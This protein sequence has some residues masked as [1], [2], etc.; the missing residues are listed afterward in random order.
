MKSSQLS[1]LLLLLPLLPLARST[2]S[3]STANPHR[4]RR[5]AQSSQAPPRLGALLNARRAPLSAL[6]APRHHYFLEFP[7]PDDDSVAD[8]SANATTAGDPSVPRPRCED[9]SAHGFL[10]RRGTNAHLN[11]LLV[12]FGGASE[13][14]A[15]P[16][17]DW[18]ARWRAGD[19]YVAAGGGALEMP[20]LRS[21]KGFSP[22][23]VEAGADL[24]GLG[25]EDVPIFL[26]G[27]EDEGDDEDG[28]TERSDSNLEA[29][30]AWWE[31]LGGDGSDPRDWSYLFVPHCTPS[32]PSATD[33][34]VRAVSDWITS[35]FEDAGGLDALVAVSG[36][37]R[38]GGCPSNVSAESG[39][40]AALFAKNVASSL[41]F[42]ST[43]SKA[44][45]VV[46]GATLWNAVGGGLGLEEAM[47]EVLLPE[48]NIEVAWVASKKSESDDS[49]S[50]WVED[51]VLKGME[52]E[53]GNSF[54]VFRPPSPPVED[55][56]DQTDLLT[57]SLYAFPDESADDGFA[58]FLDGIVEDMPWGNMGADHKKAI[59]STE[60][61]N[62]RLSFLSIFLIL[63]GLY[64]SS[65]AVYMLV[66]RRREQR[67]ED[68][69]TRSPHDLWFLALTNY[70]VI[71]LLC[72]VALPVILSLVVYAREGSGIYSLNLDFDSYLDIDTKEERVMMQYKTLL[73]YQMD[74]L[75][76]EE[77]NC[78]LMY[79][80]DSEVL[81][82]KMRR[83]LWDEEDAYEQ[84]GHPWRDHQH[85]DPR[86]RK[87]QYG[88]P[89]GRTVITFFY[90][91]RRGGNVFT[92]ETIQSIRD[93]EEFLV[94]VPGFDDF[95]FRRGGKECYPIDSVVPYFYPGL[96]GKTGTTLVGDI[97]GVL[98]SLTGSKDIVAK[99]DKYYSKEVRW[100]P[101]CLHPLLVRNLF[102][103]RFSS[104]HISLQ[105]FVVRRTLGRMS[106]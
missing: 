49:V 83:A 2:P 17:G 32:S 18:Q 7:L 45:V 1:L 97:E 38:I 71:F 36:G 41:D 39:L 15:A 100:L 65:W 75:E 10:F 52:G 28:G 94:S 74:S 99:M 33:T 66:K 20:S 31:H 82:Q 9:G 73:S 3:V 63:L 81:E 86:H 64:L 59:K 58:S 25:G 89:N 53:F 56:T 68:S 50:S 77:Q 57:C 27:L 90:Q 91:N 24:V 87:L 60:D 48:G 78:G 67:S 43:K 12:E 35:N 19:N 72:S 46:D 34:N 21:C 40:A 23:F 30:K 51:Q 80:G 55:G 76:E 42:G 95:C 4:S 85:D 102:V 84:E 11:K 26:R 70:P 8:G 104:R 92:P 44:L 16:W 96:G 88:N 79:G 69:V 103:N 13:R 105:P 98:R 5:R 61:Y 106:R 62:T 93:F 37:G 47:R 14:T 29:R 22:G 101:F 54:H 6:S